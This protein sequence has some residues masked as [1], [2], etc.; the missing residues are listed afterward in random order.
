M[1][2]GFV[3]FA[4]IMGWKGIW[5]KENP[6]E[7]AKK[8][9]D[10]LTILRKQSQ[11]MD[12]K[13]NISL[14]SDT[15]VIYSY[16]EDI[17]KEFEEHTAILIDLISLI[18]KDALLIRGA[19]SYGEYFV[20][21][22]EL[23]FVGAAIDEAASW[24]EKADSISIFLTPS[25]YIQVKNKNISGWSED[26]IVSKTA[27]FKTFL[28][29]WRQPAHIEQF[30]VIMENNAPITPEISGKYINTWRYLNEAE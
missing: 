8:L 22:H 14:I 9:E 1:K 20:S 29:D 17:E 4:D 26:H 13:I 10:I 2:K 11:D 19:T 16:S 25:A 18:L 7:M 6:I 21:S 23:T 30:K 12:T 27:K 24:H 28:L 15:F 5:L 3:T